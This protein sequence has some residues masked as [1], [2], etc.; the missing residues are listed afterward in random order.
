MKG[1]YRGMYL[2]QRQFMWL[3]F[4]VRISNILI[5]HLKSFFNDLEWLENVNDRTLC[6]L[7]SNQMCKR[8]VSIVSIV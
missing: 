2:A 6:L 1:Y 5:I 7:W 3:R 4:C 8:N